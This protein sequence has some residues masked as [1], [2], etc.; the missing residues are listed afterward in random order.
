MVDVI[1]YNFKPLMDKIFKSKESFINA[2]VDEC[3]KSEGARISTHRIRRIIDTKY[4]KS[5]LNKDTA[6]QCQN[7]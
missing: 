2:Y 6:V 3:L 5:D 7:L 4:E 1:N